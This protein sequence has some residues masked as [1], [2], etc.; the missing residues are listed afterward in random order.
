LL[1]AWYHGHFRLLL[2][3]TLRQEYREVLPRPKFREKYRLSEETIAAFLR[4][5]EAEAVPVEPGRTLPL[6]V[7]DVQ[8]EKVLAAALGGKADYPVTGDDDLL[9]LREDPRLGALRIVTVAEFR[10]LLGPE[11]A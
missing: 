8:D 11:S 5:L 2:T 1:D 9:V 4:R 6:P 3:E 10:R 7:R